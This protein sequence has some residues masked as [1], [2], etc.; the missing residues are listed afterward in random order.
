MRIRSFIAKKIS[1]P[2]QDLVNG[3][4]ILKTLEELMQT[5][6][7]SIEEQESYQFE[8]FLRLLHHATTQVPYY[9]QL[10]REHK[11]APSDI[12]EPSDIA[13]IPILTKETARLNNHLMVARDA[14]QRR[15][16]RG[17]TGG[18]TGPPL[19]LLRDI[20]DRSYTWASFYRWYRWMGLDYGDPYVQIWG[21]PA[22]LGEPLATR[23]HNN[24]KDFYYNRLKIN[25]FQ[26]N[27]STIPGVLNQIEEFRPFFIRGYLSAFIL[28]AHYML[29]NQ[30]RLNHTPLA[31]SSTTETLF[32]AYKKLIEEAFQ[33]PLYDQYGCGEC[34]S[35][36]FDGGDPRGMYLATEHAFV[37][38]LDRKDRPL[39]LDQ[40]R[41]VVTNLDN[42]VM[43]FIRYEN[44]DAGRFGEYGNPEG[45]TLPVLKEVL[46]RT[47]DTIELK[48]GSRVHGVFFT[49]ILA[50]TFKENPSSIHRF[51]VYQET[52]GMI[53]FR[54]ESKEPPGRNYEEALMEGLSRFFHRVEIVTMPE[55]PKDKN[56]KFRYILKGENG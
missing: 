23:I 54:I 14:K 51:Q 12:R 42:Y 8:K 32:P 46:G 2:L 26:L 5:Q 29:R 19:K 35:I 3:T 44:G 52:P 36:A 31:L 50:E 25:S 22:V 6:Y 10:F 24:L 4:S 39:K 47:A 43:P 20:P 21:A 40:G 16:I 9:E 17:V 41:L 28:L 49:D 37:E 1:Y 30:V 38:I 11:L 34:N 55:L 13:L 45:I 18:T 56:G 15:A 7:R 27:D 53:E 33:A 48:D